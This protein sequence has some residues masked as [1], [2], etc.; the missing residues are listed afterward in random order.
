LIR[1]HSIIAEQ[2]PTREAFF[3]GVKA[4]AQCS[5]GNLNKQRVIK[6]EDQL[7]KPASAPKFVPRH[8]HRQ[9]KTCSWYLNQV[10]VSA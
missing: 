3:I 1:A 9:A 5:L 7:L 4:V 2:E 10:L 6:L 8:L